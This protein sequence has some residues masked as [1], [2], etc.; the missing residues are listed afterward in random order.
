MAKFAG[1]VGFA[2]ST[3]VKPGV[4]QDV[5]TE[6]RLYGDIKRSRRLDEVHQVN[7]DLT[8]GNTISVVAS[9]VRPEHYS[10]IRFVEYGG[11][12]WTVTEVTEAF[13][14]LLLRL[15]GVYNGRRA[16]ANT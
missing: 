2:L 12:L 11:G 6:R 14:R 9:S 4:F 16:S 13:P 10:A 1:I 7:L 3:E 5:I 15:G 8:M